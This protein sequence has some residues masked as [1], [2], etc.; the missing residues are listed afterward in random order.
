MVTRGSAT[1]EKQRVSCPHG[2]RGARPSSPLP[3][4][5]LWL[6]LCVWSNPKPTTYVTQACRPSAL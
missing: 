6:Y 5:P 4:H 3:L 2:G 1:A